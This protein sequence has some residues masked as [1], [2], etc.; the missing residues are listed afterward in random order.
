MLEKIHEMCEEIKEILNELKVSNVLLDKLKKSKTE[1]Q[2]Q[3]QLQGQIKRLYSD[4]TGKANLLCDVF[5]QKKGSII[6][7]GMKKTDSQ[8]EDSFE[9]GVKKKMEDMSLQADTDVD[10]ISDEIV[11]E[12]SGKMEI[13]QTIDIKDEM[14]LDDEMAFLESEKNA[15]FLLT[16]CFGCVISSKRK[17]I[18][19]HIQ[20]LLV[21]IYDRAN[22]SKHYLAKD[23]VFK[24]YNRIIDDIAELSFGIFRRCDM[25]NVAYF[26]TEIFMPWLQGIPAPIRKAAKRYFRD[27]L[28]YIKGHRV[29]NV[30]FAA[31]TEGVQIGTKAIVRFIDDFP[32]ITFHVKAHQ[33]YSAMS[34]GTP[35][36]QRKGIDLKELF[37]YKVLEYIGLGPKVYFITHQ[38]EEETVFHKNALFV[39]T[40]DVS[41]TKNPEM[42]KKTFH[43]AGQLYSF[44]FDKQ[45][46]FTGDQAFK[47]EF[48]KE[49]SIPHVTPMKLEATII[50]IIARIFRLEDMNEG[51]FGRVTINKDEYISQYKWKLIDFVISKVKPERYV[52]GDP[53]STTEGFVTGNGTLGYSGTFFLCKVLLMRKREEKIDV[54]N[55]AI[56]LLEKG[57]PSLSCCVE[58]KKMPLEKAIEQAFSDVEAYVMTSN[59]DGLTRADLLGIKIDPSLDDLRIYKQAALENFNNLGLGLRS[60]KEEVESVSPKMLI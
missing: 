60:R 37:V 7:F 56:D 9:D 48:E 57:R 49:L 8:T 4:I 25:K 30:T 19:E 44:L 14:S 31:K 54:G 32:P 23:I 3:T 11:F 10:L 18:G 24:D 46:T 13:E 38:G 41:Y 27:E 45:K 33:N 21:D 42:K 55:A 59:K 1:K 47:E 15:A 35:S 52:I 22:D 34:S 43:Q 16:E 29:N 50:D 5:N 20:N 36:S 58:K 2:Q 12:N 26:H 6:E 17:T 40:Q 28:Q 51:N 53:D 39:A